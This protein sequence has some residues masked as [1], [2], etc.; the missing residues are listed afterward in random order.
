MAT[1]NTGMPS[2]I[3]VGFL[4]SPANYLNP[5][6][7]NINYNR[8][9]LVESNL[10]TADFSTTSASFV[11]V[12]GCVDTI[13][14]TGETLRVVITGSIRTQT[15]ANPAILNLNVDG[16]DVTADAYGLVYC[17]DSQAG[18]PFCIVYTVTGLAPGSHTVKLRAKGTGGAGA[19][20]YNPSMQLVDAA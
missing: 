20:V 7:D 4:V 13:V 2:S 8:S 12:T 6:V 1:W 5:V 9:P 15:V 11:D 10:N 17:N 19:Y 18:Y 16:A 3:P 14:T